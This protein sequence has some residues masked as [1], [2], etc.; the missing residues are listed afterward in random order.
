MVKIKIDKEQVDNTPIWLIS[1][2][3]SIWIALCILTTV[4]RRWDDIV[5]MSLLPLLFLLLVILTGIKVYF[6]NDKLQ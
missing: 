4:F 1:L 3:W 2:F 6:K 5:L